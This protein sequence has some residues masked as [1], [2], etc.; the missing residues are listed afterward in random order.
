MIEV[1]NCAGNENNNRWRIAPDNKKKVTAHTEYDVED[2]ES[3]DIEVAKKVAMSVSSLCGALSFG[4]LKDCSHDLLDYSYA[5]V[6]GK[7]STHSKRMMVIL[8]L[9]GNFSTKTRSEKMI[10]SALQ[11]SIKKKLG[12]LNCSVSVVNTSTFNKKVL[13]DV[14]AENE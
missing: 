7:Y 6:S 4:D 1:K 3:L 13:S 12:W 14:Q 11:T 8:F 10:L 5:I 9:E 2:R